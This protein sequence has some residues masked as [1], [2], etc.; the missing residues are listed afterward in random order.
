MKGRETKISRESETLY[1]VAGTKTKGKR[2]GKRERER[3]ERE[4][5][6]KGERCQRN[7]PGIF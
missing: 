6:R 2:E 3:G 7:M 4:G 5:G 1:I